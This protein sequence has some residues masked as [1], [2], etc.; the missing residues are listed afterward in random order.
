M[1]MKMF[2]LG[3][4]HRIPLSAHRAW[5]ASTASASSNHHR[6]AKLKARS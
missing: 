1:R 4:Q 5:A 2:L 3:T 6:A